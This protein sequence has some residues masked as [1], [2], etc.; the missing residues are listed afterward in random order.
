MDTLPRYRTAI[1]NAVEQKHAEATYSIWRDQQDYLIDWAESAANIR[2]MVD[3]L[4]FPYDGAATRLND[5]TVVIDEA[6]EVDDL[7]FELRHPG[8]IWRLEHGRPVV[9]CGRGLLR[10]DRVLT[11]D[12]KSYNFERLRVRLS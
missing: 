7:A 5:C 3:A 1:A 9:I 2:R 4:S 10:L 11:R 12:R 8:K 6:S